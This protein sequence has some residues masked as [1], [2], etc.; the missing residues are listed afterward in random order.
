MY[1]NNPA[2]LG[3]KRERSTEGLKHVQNRLILTLQAL[4]GAN[5]IDVNKW[6]KFGALASICTIAPGFQEIS[7]LPE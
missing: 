4:K 7:E 6:Y 2:P 5:P 1:Q 3:L